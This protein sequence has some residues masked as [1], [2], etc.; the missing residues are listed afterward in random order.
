MVYLW[1]IPSFV[2]QSNVCRTKGNSLSFYWLINHCLTSSLL[3]SSGIISHGK[4][5]SAPVKEKHQP[6]K[7]LLIKIWEKCPWKIECFLKD[8][9]LGGQSSIILGYRRLSVKFLPENSLLID[10]FIHLFLSSTASRSWWPSIS[11][12]FHR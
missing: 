8:L 4:G 12:C 2:E 7:I 10:D 3:L 5:K 6:S 11:C 1:E 9:F